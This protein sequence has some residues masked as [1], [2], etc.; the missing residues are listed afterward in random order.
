MVLWD[1]GCPRAAQESG[2]AEADLRRLARIFVDAPRKLAI[3]GGN[4]LGSS[5]GLAAAEAV[6]ALNILANNLGQEGGLFFTPDLPINPG[7]AHRPSTFAEIS[8]LVQRMK[9]GQVKVL[10]IHNANPAY[11]LPAELG[12]VEAL[13]SVPLVISFASFPDETAL[14]ADYVLPD[15]TSLESWGYQKV[16]TGGD[17][18]VISGLQPVVAPLYDT[19]ATTDVL[20]AAV[21]SIG[22]NLSAALPFQDEVD[23]LQK[24]VASLMGQGGF[25]HVSDLQS[26]WSRWRQN[27]GWWKENAGLSKPEVSMAFK[28]LAGIEP[29]RSAGDI[30]EYPFYLLIFPHFS[31]GDGNPASTS[32]SLGTPDP[33]G[34]TRGKTWVEI[35]PFTARTLGVRKGDIVELSS[36][37]GVIEAVVYETPAILPDVVAVPLWQEHA[38][39]EYYAERRDSNPLRLLELSSK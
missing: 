11:E 6:L 25:Y 9:S 7:L 21:Q 17:R 16:V 13:E 32:G 2:V 23:F 4:A 22:G 27:G 12:F 35:N 31:S 24:S 29:A 14:L 5:S 28:R 38:S 33:P 18:L 36:P 19:R 26:F 10:F 3:P 1:R 15:H 34:F 20:L 30:Q 8:A 37:A 39:L